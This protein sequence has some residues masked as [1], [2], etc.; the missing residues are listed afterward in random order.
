MEHKTTPVGILVASSYIPAGTFLKTDMVDKKS[1]PESYVS[2][3]TIHDIQE[4]DGLMTLVP[5]SAGEPILSNFFG[6]GE[7]ALSTAL[8]RGFRAYTLEVDEP[9]SVGN[10]IRPGNHVD[11]LTKMESDKRVITSFVFQDVQVLAVGHKMVG[12]HRSE[13]GQESGGSDGGGE[14]SYGTVTLAVTPEQAEILMFLE[15]RPLR[16][17]LRGPGDEE[18]VS[19]PSQSESEILSKLGRFVPKANHS[20][21]IIRGNSKQGD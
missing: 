1:I 14:Q 6:A 16:L 3:G 7:A 11:I 4:V 2:P 5:I 18:I 13:K 19:V 21:Q 9:N 12:V 17:I 20:I 8:S 15:G 10:L